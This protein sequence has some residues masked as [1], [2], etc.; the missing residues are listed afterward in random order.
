[1]C[2]TILHNGVKCSKEP[3]KEFCYIHENKNL[4]KRISEL[5]KSNEDLTEKNSWLADDARRFQFIQKMERIKN[6]LRPKCNI[7]N[8]D[9]IYYFMIQRKNHEFLSNL[10]DC[11]S[12]HF[13][14]YLE[15][16]K[17]RNHYCHRAY[18]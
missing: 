13:E 9:A 6:K 2:N 15:M 1:M 3:T 10:L 8:I 5:E 17:Q 12:N 14:K 11:D 4:K 18:I 7:K 16:L